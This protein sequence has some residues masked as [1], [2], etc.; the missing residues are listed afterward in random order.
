MKA[1]AI[2]MMIGCGLV[3]T[4]IASS[5]RAAECNAT[6]GSLECRAVDEQ[7]GDHYC[8]VPDAMPIR[9]LAPADKTN[10]PDVW[11][12]LKDTKGNPL[13]I[14]LDTVGLSGGH[15]QGTCTQIPNFFHGLKLR[16]IHEDGSYFMQLFPST[17][18]A[19]PTKIKMTEGG[20]DGKRLW[21]SGQD[22]E[23]SKYHYYLFLRNLKPK[24]ASKKFPKFLYAV[25]Y[26]FM[27][28]TCWMNAPEVTGNIARMKPKKCKNL[29]MARSTKA[30]GLDE[31]GVGGGG[32]QKKP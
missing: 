8:L 21:L 5:L 24:V 20:P 17:G 29:T 11:L 4:G 1:S 25:V 10:L 2:F 30:G 7:I 9:E 27:D 32:E 14:D 15:S 6:G 12:T 16:V 26:D 18:S 19:E 31:T 3:L 28:N 13:D 22:P 23:E